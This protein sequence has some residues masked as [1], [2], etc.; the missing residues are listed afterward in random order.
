MINI[1]LPPT[2]HH[3]KQSESESHSVMSNFLRSHG[4][5]SPWNSPGQNTGM[6]SLSL[7][8][9]IFPTQG[10]NPGL[11]HC[12]WILYQLSQKGSP[13]TLEWVAYSFSSRSSWPRN[14]TEVSHI[15]GRFLTT[16]VSGK[17]LLETM[18]PPNI[19]TPVPLG[20]GVRVPLLAPKVSFCLILLS[21]ANLFRVALALWKRRTI[22]IIS[23]Y[24]ILGRG[25]ILPGPSHS[26]PA[27]LCIHGIEPFR[28]TEGPSTALFSCATEACVDSE[29]WLHLWPSRLLV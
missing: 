25:L 5:Y 8:Q 17:P 22:Q 16:E 23:S 1:K 14:Q 12:R 3:W 20:T 26:Q 11:P 15:S 13:K 24:A 29:K 21:I 6:G 10:L 7:L 18:L 19:L 9:G 28:E 2:S 4:L 27:L